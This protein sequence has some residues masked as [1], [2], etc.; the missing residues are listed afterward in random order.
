[1]DILYLLF[2]QSIR[3]GLGEVWSNIF[4]VVTSLGESAVTYL[5]LGLIYWCID[6]G[7][8]QL[9]MW[10]ISVA[11]TYNQ[12]LKNV[13]KIERPWVRD[14]R[15]VPVPEALSGA[16]GYSFPSG[17]TT[18]VTATWG[19]LGVARWKKSDRWFSIVCWLIVAGVAFSRNILGVHT[20]QDVLVSLLIGLALVVAINRVL[21]WVEKGKNRDILV[22]IFGCLICFL[23]M[24]RFGCLSNAGAGMGFLIGWLAERRFVQFE[25]CTGWKKRLVRWLI[26]AAGI[27]ICLCMIL[28]ILQGMMAGK[29]AGFFGTFI[30]AI[31]ISVGYPFLFQL[32]EKRR[33]SIHR[34]M[35]TTLYVIGILIVIVLSGLYIAD[36]IREKASEAQNNQQSA[37]TVIAHRGYSAVYPENTLSAFAG[38][39]DIGADYIELDVQMTAD[40][41]IVVFHDADLKRTVGKEGTIAD[42][43][44]EQLKQFDVGG[45]FDTSFSGERIPTLQ[46]VF[47]LVQSS[48]CDIYLELKDIGDRASF[49]EQTMDITK[50]CGMTDRCVF[51][52][53]RY[54]YLQQIKMMNE[55]AK[56]LYNTTSGMTTLSKEYPADYYGLYIETV[57]S[58]TIQAIHESGN[59]AFVWTV[60]EPTQMSELIKM[61]V[62]GIVTNNPGLARTVIRPEY[63]YLVER[64]EDSFALPGLYGHTIPD[65]CND[66]VV[67]GLTKA[68]NRI[69][70]SAYSK[71]GENNS[72]LYM[73]DLQGNLQN[74]ID[75]NFKAH[76]G[77]IAYDEEN[78]LLWV[79]GPEGHV[80]GISYDE[81]VSGSYVGD[82][83]IDFDAGLINH[84]QS[85][86]ASFLTYNHGELFV[87]SY[88][89]GKKGH[90]RRYDL[91]DP[92]HPKLLDEVKIPE[93][94]QGMTFEY[95]AFNQEWYLWFSQG[96][97][98][99]DSH[100]LKFKYD[101]GESDYRKSIEEHV[102]PEGMEQIQMS[103]RGMYI[104]FE[105]AARPYRETARVVNDQVFVVR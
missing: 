82:I 69:F 85:K 51:A 3:E 59:K 25:V 104:L 39:M 20:P 24:L 15:V 79:T 28:P 38:A 48:D 36:S 9:M 1:M 62:D 45:W 70:I 6:K 98:T 68:G 60:D 8:G 74:I 72:I 53:F 78:A 95:D 47:E 83:L 37:T 71:S 33:E 84:N 57:T 7:A 97:Q 29:Y 16:G 27:M 23:P 55:N 103:A 26:G 92:C 105:S 64:Y 50:R 5:L 17:H 93:R 90:L 4:L 76:T 77:G 21:D 87:G 41:Q 22:C 65:Q 18:R 102:M 101:E 100:L 12:V 67:Q 42:F 61:G 11:C 13:F 86:V 40:D 73:L 81:V 31:F 56:T 54:E 19:A 96:Y 63:E 44:L 43:T 91:S 30:L 80:Y 32:W 46:E 75:L 10:N 58:E 49:V 99:E 89:D 35:L 2:L 52:S 14:A 66:M 94:I 34:R 88:V